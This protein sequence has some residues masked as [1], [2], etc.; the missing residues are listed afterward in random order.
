MDV[1][2]PHQW[3]CSARGIAVALSVTAVVLLFTFITGHDS[4]QAQQAAH[5][6]MTRPIVSHP[7]AVYQPMA[8]T[9]VPS[10]ALPYR[11]SMIMRAAEEGE[12]ASSVEAEPQP[13]KN[14]E[15]GYS[16]KDVTIITV[17]LTVFGFAIYYGLQAFG[18]EEGQAGTTTMIVFNAALLFG[19]VGSYL[20]RVGTKSMTYVQQLNDYEEAVMLKR[21]EEMD[22][23]EREA[24]MAAPM[25]KPEKPNDIRRWL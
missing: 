24:M 14:T 6:S 25:P 22:E 16:R 3:A 17:G 21:Y 15:F 1:E 9:Q 13:V 12:D 18:M 20:F 8:S 7:S 11:T 5:V 2:K 10:R 19:W 4:L 23:E